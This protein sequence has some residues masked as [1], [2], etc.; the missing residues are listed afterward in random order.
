DQQGYLAL[1]ELLSKAWL[2]NQYR[3]RAEI[4]R[5]WLQ[6]KTGLIVLSGGRAGDVGQLLESGN[7]EEAAVVAASWAKA[8]PNSYFIELQRSVLDGDEAYVQEAM[9]LAARVDVPVVATHTF[10]FLKADDFRTH[11]ARVCIAQGEQLD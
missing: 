5:E 3:G 8:F 11:E 7:T 9:C 1:C 6:D 4:R 2:E 10:Q